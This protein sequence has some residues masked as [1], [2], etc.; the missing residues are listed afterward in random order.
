MKQKMVRF[1]S[2]LKTKI[3]HSDL[4][5]KVVNFSCDDKGKFKTL[6]G[7]IVSVMLRIMIFTIAV[8]LIVEIFSKSNSKFSL[9]TIQKDLTNDEEKHYFA[10]N[11]IFIGL[12]LIGPNSEILLDPSYFTLQI[13]QA[14]YVN[15]NTINGVPQN[16]SQISYEYWNIDHPQF[17]NFLSNTTKSFKY[18]CPKFKDFLH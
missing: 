3:I 6:F 13:Q 16:S 10:Q 2:W 14:N 9:T 11:D 7:G 18:I 17:K 1:G 15:D 12:N 4:Y 8:S 5:P